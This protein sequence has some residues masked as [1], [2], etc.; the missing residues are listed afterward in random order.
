[1]HRGRNTLILLILGLGLGAY[2]YFVEMKRTPASE[3]SATTRPKVFGAN[4]DAAKIEELQ[5]KSSAGERTALKKSGT[6]WQIVAPIQSAVDDTEVSGI[7]TNLATLEASRVIEENTKDLTK[8]G[9]AEPRVEVSFKVA[10][11]KDY[12]RLLVGM[13][14][15]TGGDLYAKLA[16]EQ[17]VLL[18]PA[19]LESTLD[20][21]TFQLRDKSILKFD[22]D[23]IDT[24]EVESGA[25]RMKLVKQ[26]D[27]WTLTEPYRAKTDSTTVEALIGRL[28]SGQMK[29]LASQEPKDLAEYGLVKPDA[30]VTLGSGSART[31]LLIGKASTAANTEAGAKPGPAAKA[32]PA[33]PS[34]GTSAE[35]GAADGVFA[36]DG[37]RPM[38]FTVD[39]SLADDLTKGPGDYRKKDVFDFREFTGT[40]L[41]VTRAGATVTFEKKKGKEKDAVEKWRQ[42]QPAKEIDA[43]KIQDLVSKVAGLRA[44]SFV[45]TLPAGATELATVATQFDE[46]KKSEKVA[47]YKA[48]SDYFAVRPDDAGAAKLP[49]A[50]VEDIVKALDGLK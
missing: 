9:L 20:R 37:S 17:K 23:K 8:Y 31:S 49:A 16:N 26:G 42:T 28:A 21:S 41:E 48:G 2:V 15:P 11:D 47:L 12:R 38:V 4:I 32:S 29:S 46:G 44:D 50:G 39:K 7:T 6:A 18:I 14:T 22:R 36:K 5:L 1:M 27:A 34:A 33:A 45:D 25:T 30:N 35:A 3:A 40:T 43:S 19:Y 10:G 24:V 13:K